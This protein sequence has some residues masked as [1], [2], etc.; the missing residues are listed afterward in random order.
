MIIIEAR[1][2]QEPEQVS[3]LTAQ[4]EKLCRELG[5]FMGLIAEGKAP[6]SVMEEIRKQEAKK[7]EWEQEQAKFE[8]PVQMDELRLRRLRKRACERLEDYRGLVRANIPKARQA[9]RKLL[10]DEKGEFKKIVLRS[11]RKGGRTAF[12]FQG[13]VSLGGVLY[14]GGAEERT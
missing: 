8:V 2:R 14:N 9:L 12:E 13:L 6:E 3:K 5:R 1:N 10:R 4:I 7:K 11:T